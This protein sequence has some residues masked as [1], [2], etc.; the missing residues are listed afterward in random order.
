MKRV[1]VFRPP[2]A[3]EE[4][5]GAQNGNHNK[6]ILYRS[7][8]S[9]NTGFIGQLPLDGVAFSNPRPLPVSSPIRQVRI[10]AGTGF[11]MYA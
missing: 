10:L 11:A 4:A 8:R 9:G 7:A 3:E 2:R 5:L 6:T 1:D